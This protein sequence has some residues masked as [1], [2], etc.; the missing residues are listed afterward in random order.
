MMIFSIGPLNHVDS[1]KGEEYGKNQRYSL[2]WNIV[3]P[4]ETNSFFSIKLKLGPSINQ[5]DSFFRGREFS[6]TKTVPFLI[7]H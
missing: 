3:L 1:F 6:K 2:P 4:P 7:F 5:V